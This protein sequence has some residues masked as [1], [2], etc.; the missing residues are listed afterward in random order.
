MSREDQAAIARHELKAELAD[1]VAAAAFCVKNRGT[2]VLVYP[3]VRFAHLAS[4]LAEK[5][6]AL[7]RLQPVYSYPEDVQARLMLVEAVK[8]GGEECRILPPL[9]IYCKRDGAYSRQIQQMYE[10]KPAS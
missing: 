1:M 9:Y 3:A 8:N 10:P 7:K 5:K 4:G 6:L 2:V